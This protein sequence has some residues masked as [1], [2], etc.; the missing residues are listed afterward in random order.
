VYGVAQVPVSLALK[1]RSDLPW[2]CVLPRVLPKEERASECAAAFSTTGGI[3]IDGAA[4]IAER[5]RES[6]ARSM[7]IAY[8]RNAAQ[9]EYYDSLED[10]PNL[11]SSVPRSC[12]R[13]HWVRQRYQ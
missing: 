6:P 5:R 3:E 2:Q 13:R 9:E 4:V 8:C 12:S 11:R 7:R 10:G 1:V